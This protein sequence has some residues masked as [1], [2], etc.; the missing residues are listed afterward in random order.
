M[1]FGLVFRS[2]DIRCASCLGCLPNFTSVPRD[3]ED[4]ERAKACQVALAGLL[5]WKIEPRTL[6]DLE[7]GWKENFLDICAD[8]ELLPPAEKNDAHIVAETAVAEI[9]ILVTSDGPLLNAD[10][11]E[12]NIGLADS[13][14]HGVQ[15]LNA[16]TLGAPRPSKT[17]RSSSPPG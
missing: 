16:R 2:A 11:S 14:L 7:D 10:A 8:R 1:N 13:G 5:E 9:P 4:L 3:Q 6:T 12:L 15:I 17:I